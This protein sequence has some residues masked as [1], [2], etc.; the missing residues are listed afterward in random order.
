MALR[1]GDRLNKPLLIIIPAYNEEKSLGRVLED[2]RNDDIASVADVLVMNDAST[3]STAEI[4]WNGGAACVTHVFNL[5]YGGGLQVGYKYAD[6]HRYRYVIQIDGDG[7]HDVSNVAK[8]YSELTSER[9]PDIVLGSRFME[10]SS[11]YE[12]GLLRKTAYSWFRWMLKRMTG[13]S[14]ADPTTGLQGLSR[15]AIRF[16]SRFRHFDDRYPDA[17]MLAQMMLLGFRVEQIPAVMH[18]RT[19]GSSM[20]SGL[21]KPA[22]YM[23]RMSLSLLSVWIRVRVL[24]IQAEEARM[25][26]DEENSGKEVCR[27]QSGK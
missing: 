9:R 27:A 11:P 17:N 4:A 5:G 25:L 13:Q 2:L 15:R 14:I 6:R 7:Q 23:I 26:L 24:R 12:P 10:G 8:L 22:I 3:D 21:I 16:Y 18:Y 1:I 19:S 20:H